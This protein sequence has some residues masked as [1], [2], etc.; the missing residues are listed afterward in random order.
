MDVGNVLAQPGDDNK[1]MTMPPDALQEFTFITG[2]PPAEFGNEQGGIVNFTVRSGTNQLH[3]SAYEF[4]TGNYFQA[5]N[6]RQKNLA[7][8]I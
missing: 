8:D 1:T 2:D 4:N 3:G 7:K 5:R 6:F